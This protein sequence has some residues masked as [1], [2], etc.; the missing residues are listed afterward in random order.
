VEDNIKSRFITNSFSADMY[1]DGKI[2]IYDEHVEIMTEYD[3]V[4]EFIDW[5]YGVYGGE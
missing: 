3:D 1:Q 5:V 4:E 2:K